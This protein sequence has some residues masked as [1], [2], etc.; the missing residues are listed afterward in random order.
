MHCTASFSGTAAAVVGRPAFVGGLHLDSPHGLS[1]DPFRPYPPA[2]C[3][4]NSAQTTAVATATFSDSEV[5][6]SAG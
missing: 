1:C 6:R 3:R 2:A 4:R 5:G